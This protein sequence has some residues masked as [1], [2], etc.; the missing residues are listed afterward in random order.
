MLTF[1]T[2]FKSRPYNSLLQKNNIVNAHI[3]SDMKTSQ[4]NKNK[5]DQEYFDIYSS[6]LI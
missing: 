3:I 4:G 6:L 1:D 5:C 2:L